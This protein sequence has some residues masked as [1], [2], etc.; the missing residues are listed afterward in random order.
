MAAISEPAP[1]LQPL[2]ESHNPQKRRRHGRHRVA[3]SRLHL[4]AGL[5]G[6]TALPTTI[7]LPPSGQFKP[8]SVIRISARE[9]AVKR[10]L[11]NGLILNS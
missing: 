3:D 1:T 9:I 6:Y 7:R 11:T 8:A 5:R 4:R 10:R 2:R